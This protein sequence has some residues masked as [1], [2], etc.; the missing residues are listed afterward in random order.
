MKVLNSDPNLSNLE[1][2]QLRP[3][4]SN[5]EGAQ[6]RPKSSNLD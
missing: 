2:A 4:S 1:G 5:L 3:K 6:L